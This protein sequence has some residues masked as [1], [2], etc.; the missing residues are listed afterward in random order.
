M[1][2]YK[3]VADGGYPITISEELATNE[4][5]LLATIAATS[6]ELANGD[7]NALPEKDGVVII[8]IKKKAGAHGALNPL[9]HL[10]ECKGGIN[11]AL[12][13]WQSLQAGESLLVDIPP[14]TLLHLDQEIAE[15]IDAGEAQGACMNSAIARLDAAAPTPAPVVVA[16]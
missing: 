13:M 2:I 12:A 16:L 7:V 4:D 11:P 14:E 10:D 15:A 5:M 3:V 1:T 9:Q 8:E 6:P